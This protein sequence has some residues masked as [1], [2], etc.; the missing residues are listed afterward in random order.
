MLFK[1]SA[2]FPYIYNFYLTRYCSPQ[3]LG[4]GSILL[5]VGGLVRLPLGVEAGIQSQGE[6]HEAGSYQKTEHLQEEEQ[7]VVI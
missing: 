4:V 3:Q 5:L 7:E 6:G 1:F 2:L